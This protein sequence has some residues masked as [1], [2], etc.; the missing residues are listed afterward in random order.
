MPLDPKEIVAK[1]KGRKTRYNEE[2]HCELLVKIMTNKNKGTMSAFCV[3]AL[4]G[5]TTFWDWISAHETFADLYSFCKMFAR[6]V[7]EEDG[8]ELRDMTMPIGTISYAFEHWKLVGWS[9]F[10][11]SKN[12]RIRVRLN[13]NDTPDKHYAQLIKQA[14]DG[15]YTASEIKQLMEAINVGLNTHQV[16]A[17]QKEIDQLKSDFTTMQDNTNAHN[18]GTNKGIA[19]KD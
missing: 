17:L 16:F 10:G 8:R 2:E 15:D 14:A 12:S 19:Q 4:I 13:P 18:S 11:I 6:E 1:F 5:E 9:R 7:W 3:A